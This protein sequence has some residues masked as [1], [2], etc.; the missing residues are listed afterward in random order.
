MPT[1]KKIFTVQNLTEKF[2]ESKGLVLA[3][4]CGLDV[5]QMNELRRAIKKA[6]GE[7][8]VVKNTLL[9]LASENYQLPITNCQLQG[10]TAA[11]WVYEEDTAPLKALDQFIAKASLPKIKSAF[12]NGE[13]I[14]I[15]RVRELANLP[16]LNELKAKL[17]GTLQSPT[18]G[19]I[20]A[21]EWNMQKIVLVLNAKIKKQNAK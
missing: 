3:D 7:F 6:G 2:K 21:L 8:E 1:S 11:L 15:E 16:S 20:N 4:Y 13:L 5:G 9:R 17:V 19:L 14:S 12:W 10:P 18:H